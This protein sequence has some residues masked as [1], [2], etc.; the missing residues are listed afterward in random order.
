MERGLIVYLGREM[1][2]DV[3]KLHISIKMKLV[4]L[5]D[6]IGTMRKVG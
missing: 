1:H 6:Q 3:E 4:N 2:G 5:I